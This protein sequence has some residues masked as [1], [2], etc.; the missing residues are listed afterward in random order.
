MPIYMHFEGISGDVTD[1]RHRKWIE[2]LTLNWGVA[3]SIRTPV[4]R[5]AK[6]ESSNPNCRAVWIQKTVDVASGKM[7]G[8]CVA[9]VTGRKVKFRFVGTDSRIY[10][11]IGLE[12]VL[13]SR[14]NFLTISQ[15]GGGHALLETWDLNFTKIEFMPY[16]TDHTGAQGTTPFRVTFDIATNT[17]G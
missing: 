5:A 6:R 13:L 8:E 17:K 2:V 1:F 16:S 3:R 15:V 7:F 14:Y 12:N 11:H 10:M 9:G 4:G